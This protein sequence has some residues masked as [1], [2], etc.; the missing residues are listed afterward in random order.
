QVQYADQH[1]SFTLK[2][3]T[4]L[5]RR[6]RVLNHELS[7][8]FPFTILFKNWHNVEK[9]SDMGPKPVTQ[10][11][12]VSYQPILLSWE[13]W[14]TQIYSGSFINPIA[15]IINDDL[16]GEDLDNITLRY[17]IEDATANLLI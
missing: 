11:V 14:R 9:F 7:G 3:A 8:I 2:T 12:K 1:H 16:K 4:E 15:H 17:G 13:L 6:M 5:F 10:Q